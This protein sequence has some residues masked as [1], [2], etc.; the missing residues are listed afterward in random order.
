MEDGMERTR[1]G[2]RTGAL[3]ALALLG[4]V[5]ALA[6]GEESRAALLPERVAIPG[7]QEAP[8]PLFVKADRRG[9]VWLF[10]SGERVP[11]PLR[12]NDTLGDAVKLRATGSSC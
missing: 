8:E 11:Q 9:G 3:R 10:H 5:L 7:L 2:R 12:P 1:A 6:A 4:S